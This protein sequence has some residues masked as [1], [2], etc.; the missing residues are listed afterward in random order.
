MHVSPFYYRKAIHPTTQQKW[1][2]K[3]AQNDKQLYLRGFIV[4]KGMEILIKEG[5]TEN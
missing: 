2:Q 1:G 3:T 5:E 4:R